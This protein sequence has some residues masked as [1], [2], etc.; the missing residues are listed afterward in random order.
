MKLLSVIPYLE[1]GNLGPRTFPQ[2]YSGPNADPDELRQLRQM[3]YD[4][5]NLAP[6]SA[7]QLTFSEGGHGV[8]YVY[9]ANQSKQPHGTFFAPLKACVADNRSRS[10]LP[11]D[12]HE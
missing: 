3:L 9:D 12:P 1:D 7:I 2:S 4:E 11:L 5:E 10:T 6:P 8:I